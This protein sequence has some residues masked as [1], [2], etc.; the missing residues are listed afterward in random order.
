M[1]NRD[2]D[3]GAA[4]GRYSTLRPAVPPVT[5]K[6]TISGWP[7]AVSFARRRKT[8]PLADATDRPSPGCRLNVSNGCE[9]MG[10]PRSTFYDAP[11]V[12]TG[13]E[14]IVARLGMICD[15]FETYG[16]RE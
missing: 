16:Y 8:N 1:A 10:L 15:E 6:V 5:P 2:V 4:P 3:G 14:E 12:V 13:N 9:L 11:A 7:H